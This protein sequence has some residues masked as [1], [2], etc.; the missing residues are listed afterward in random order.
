MG[1]QAGH[2]GEDTG[3]GG[4]RGDG[5]VAEEGRPPGAPRAGRRLH[6]RRPRPQHRQWRQHTEASRGCADLWIQGRAGDVRDA[7]I[8]V[9]GSQEAQTAGDLLEAAFSMVRPVLVDCGCAIETI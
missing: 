4:A 8:R 3:A 9:G 5:L 6:P 2:R 7:D 1:V